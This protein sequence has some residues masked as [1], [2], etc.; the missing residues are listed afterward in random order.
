MLSTMSIQ[1]H[2][3]SVFEEPLLL[4]TLSPVDDRFARR[5]L[6]RT[7]VTVGGQDVVALC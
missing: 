2:V 3:V 6:L 7:T 4:T 5:S 1:D